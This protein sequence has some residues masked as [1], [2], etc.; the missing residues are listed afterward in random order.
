MATILV[1]GDPDSRDFVDSAYG[2]LAEVTFASSASEAID[3]LKKNPP[4]LMIG[5]LA[6]DQSK[7]LELLPFAAE[8]RV[9]VVVVDC[10]YTQMNEGTLSAVKM[11]AECIG[12]MAW[13]DMRTSVA[14]SGL[15]VAAKEIR[16]I[17][18]D[19]LKADPPPAFSL[20]SL[21]K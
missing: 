12:V 4:S 13:W 11:L 3:R 15:G 2:D 16:Q 5:T 19:A 7:F 21:R 6:F 1:V 17:V 8:R 10:P 9:K 14:K 18:Q 20:P